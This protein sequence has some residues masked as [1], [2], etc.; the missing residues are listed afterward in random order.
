M[1]SEYAHY[2]MGQEVRQSLTGRQ[3]EAV[4]A[5]PELYQ[6]GLHGPDIL[7][8]YGPLSSN[9][10]NRVGYE[11]H[12]RPGRVFFATARRAVLDSREP[13]AALAY[14]CGALDH[15]AL[16][17]ACHP[18][19]DEKIA[20]SGVTHTRIE[21]EFDR[22]LMLA[23]GLDPVSHVLTGHIRP[24]RAN[25]EVIAP[26]YPGVTA[27][28]V[29]K[30]LRSMV[31]YLGLLRAPNALKRGLLYAAMRAVGKYRELSGHIVDPRGDPAC[32]DSSARLTELYRRTLAG[33]GELHRALDRFLAGGGELPALFDRTFDGALP[34][35]E[36]RI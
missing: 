8:Y 28:E 15:F 6:I 35:Q 14:A 20:A 2:R 4:E 26:F 18:C 34:K 13:G 19:V 27:G 29:E 7:F 17:A 3:R 22:S 12:A 30:A 32:A 1:P 16:D 31:F 11:T 10:V 24:T 5:W 36:G 9:R 33:A 21:V 23:D 25:A